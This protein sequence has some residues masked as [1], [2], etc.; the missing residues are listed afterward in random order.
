MAHDN[1]TTADRFR[2]SRSRPKQTTGFRRWA[3]LSLGVLST[4]L[5]VI[6]IFLPLLPTVPL[7]LLAAFCFARSSRRLH[8][9]L[10]RHK[11]LGPMIRGYLDGSGVT[12]RT[13]AY[14]IAM[15]WLTVPFSAFL[16][17]PI[18]AVR[19]LLLGIALAVSI[20]IYRLPTRP[21]KK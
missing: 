9:W 10:L 20:Y 8:L 17:V 16:F 4:G 19:I 2:G 14:A 21:A 12:R 3:L 18:M 5:G 1:S 6:G 11:Q 15:I 13:K 7:L